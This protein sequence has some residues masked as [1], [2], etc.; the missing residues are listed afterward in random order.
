MYQN[1]RDNLLKLTYD[2][3]IILPSVVHSCNF[4]KNPVTNNHKC[5]KRKKINDSLI[6]DTKNKMCNYKASSQFLCNRDFSCRKLVVYVSYWTRLPIVTISWLIYQIIL[7]NCWSKFYKAWV[8][9]VFIR[10]ERN[11]NVNGKVLKRN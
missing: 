3:T 7:T 11:Y 9:K 1:H 6:T 2:C 10:F 4:I 5:Q 8:F